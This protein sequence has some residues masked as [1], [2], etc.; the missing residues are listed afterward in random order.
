MK[1][2]KATWAKALAGI[3]ELT[4]NE[5]MALDWDVEEP[6]TDG[7]SIFRLGPQFPADLRARLG[8]A[9]TYRPLRIG[10]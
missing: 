4:E 6:P 1:Y 7:P 9:E 5:V 3:L 2:D 8:G 10:L